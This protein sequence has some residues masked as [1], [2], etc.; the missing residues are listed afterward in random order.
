LIQVPLIH[1]PLVLTPLT[2][3]AME[4]IE[5][6]ANEMGLDMMGIYTANRNSDDKVVS[7]CIRKLASQIDS[8]SKAAAIILMVYGP[9]KARS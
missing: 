7:E 9:Y 4:Q 2:A 8:K 6:Y 1:T 5:M 3:I